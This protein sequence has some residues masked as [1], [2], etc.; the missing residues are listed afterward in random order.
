MITTMSLPCT[1]AKDTL[2]IKCLCLQGFG[3]PAEE[4][5]MNTLKS[6]PEWYAE[7]C[8]GVIEVDAKDRYALIVPYSK[9][10]YERLLEI[11][12]LP[13]DQIMKKPRPDFL[14]PTNAEVLKYGY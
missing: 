6:N 3:W 9:K 14:M 13:S 11:E 5:L 10:I 7:L 4:A 2:T 12:P 1:Y 8:M